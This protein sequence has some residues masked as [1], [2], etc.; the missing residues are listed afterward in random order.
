M[1]RRDNKIK[2]NV[3]EIIVS[4]AQKSAEENRKKNERKV[5]RKRNAAAEHQSYKTILPKSLEHNEEVTILKERIAELENQETEKALSEP[6]TVPDKE[7][8]K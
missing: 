8:I 5:R 6:T 3:E 2:S 7:E 1:T 4:A